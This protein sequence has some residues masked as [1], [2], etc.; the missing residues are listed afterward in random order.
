MSEKHR[1]NLVS[2][3]LPKN[4][5]GKTFYDKSPGHGRLTRSFQQL[6]DDP[7][8]GVLTSEAGVGKTTGIR[9]LCMALPRPDYLVLYFCDTTVSP[10]DLYRSLAGELGVKPSHRRGQLW[11]DIKRALV[12]M[13]DERH[14]APVIVLDEAQHLSD[15]F[16]FD[17]SGFLNFA[18]D[19]R[20]LLTLWL[21]GLPPLARRLHMAQHAALATR[22]AAEIRL[23]PLDR[24]TFAAAVDHAF[25]AAGATQKVLSDPA[26]EMLFRSCRG[27]LRVASKVLRAALRIAHARGQGFLDEPTLKDALDEVGA[28]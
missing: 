14:T 5:Q 15:S 22:I 19:S 2:Y 11:A 27:V 25:K 28:T 7:G 26:L 20:D 17:L 3:P 23:E 1:F 8:L 18:F 12:H 24:D 4:A 21:V 16:L 10:L 9:N 6:I 13:V